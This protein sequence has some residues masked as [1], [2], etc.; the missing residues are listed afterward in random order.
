MTASRERY[1]PLALISEERKLAEMIDQR[2]RKKTPEPAFELFVNLIWISRLHWNLQRGVQSLS[3][4]IKGLDGAER[5][6]VDMCLT[7]TCNVLVE[8]QAGNLK[9]RLGE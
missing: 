3:S 6:L 2:S 9:N 4:S 8:F 5:N 7:R 1:I